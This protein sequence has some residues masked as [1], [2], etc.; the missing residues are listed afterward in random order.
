MTD[1]TPPS[2]IS[3]SGGQAATQAETDARNAQSNPANDPLAAAKPTRRRI[4]LSV[5]RRKLEIPEGTCPGFVL[6]WFLNPNVPAA[7]DAGYEFVLTNEIVLNQT[8]PANSADSSGNTDLGTQVSILG[9]KSGENGEPERLVLMK[10]REEWWRED[11]KILD[12]HNAAIIQAIFP[13]VGQKGEIAGSGEM[14]EQDRGLAYV[15]TNQLLRPMH[16]PGLGLGQGRGALLNRGL[17][18]K[19]GG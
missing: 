18:K 1:P 3:V 4:P 17:A 7:I 15:K 11:R 10:I 19:V 2:S 16:Q 13:T 5:P 6:Y 12:D 14:S 9:N 8:N